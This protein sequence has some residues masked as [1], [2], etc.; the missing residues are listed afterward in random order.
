V[1]MQGFLLGQ[2]IYYVLEVWECS[3]IVDLEMWLWSVST[4][5][6]L[7]WVLIEGPIWPM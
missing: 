5:C 3:V 2:N 6:S 7:R 4:I 1:L